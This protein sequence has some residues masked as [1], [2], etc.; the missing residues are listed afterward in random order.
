M[1]ASGLPFSIPWDVHLVTSP[2][3]SRPQEQGLQPIEMERRS[4]IRYPLVLNVRYCTP[5]RSVPS[6]EGQV[7][8]MSSGGAFIVSSHT[9]AVGAELE[10]CME[11]PSLLDGSVRL[12]LVALGRVVRCSESSF[13][14]SFRRHQ[15]RTL[16]SKLQPVPSPS[17]N[18]T[19][20]YRSPNIPGPV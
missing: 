17:L 8:N 15:F 6:R 9:L 7:V 11:W 20:G 14:L 19:Q 2:L 12:Q 18:K 3:L 16:K 13:A 5:G 1:V 4:K 10:V